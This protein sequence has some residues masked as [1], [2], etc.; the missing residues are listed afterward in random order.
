V[1]RRCRHFSCLGGLSSNT[2]SKKCLYLEAHASNALS[3]ALS[4]EIKSNIKMVYG[5]LER[6]NLLWKTLEQMYG[7]INDKRSLSSIPENTSSSS[8][9]HIDQYQEEQSSIHKEEVKYVSLRKPDGP[10]SETR[11][12]GFD[13]TKITLTE[14]EDCSMSSFDVDDDNDDTD[15]EYDDQEFLLEF[16][17]LI[18]KHM[19]LQKRHEILLCSHEKLI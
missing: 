12:S 18:S 14:E 13:R 5:L 3:S 15:D 8:S 19:K 16:Q 4:A 2:R 6:A 7:S 10:V 1:D 9:I 17:K 11:T